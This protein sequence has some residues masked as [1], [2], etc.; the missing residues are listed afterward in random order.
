MQVVFRPPKTPRLHCPFAD[1]EGQHLQGAQSER[2]GAP[3]VRGQTFDKGEIVIVHRQK[4]MG[5]QVL[6]EIDTLVGV[7]VK[8]WLCY[9][10]STTSPD[11]YVTNILTSAPL[12]SLSPKE[13]IPPSLCCLFLMEKWSC[14]LSQGTGHVCSPPSSGRVQDSRSLSDSDLGE[15]DVLFTL[16]PAC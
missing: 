16:R 4:Q 11:R 1:H 7:A 3:V 2:T 8:W 9:V 5:V 6:R 12:W 15:E 14:L 10:P 13:T